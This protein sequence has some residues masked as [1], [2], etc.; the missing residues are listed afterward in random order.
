MLAAV[1]NSVAG[2]DRILHAQSSIIRSFGEASVA[3][4]L[5]ALATAIGS[6]IFLSYARKPFSE[7]GSGE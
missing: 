5:L 4:G 1:S 6:M 3:L 7:S 2:K